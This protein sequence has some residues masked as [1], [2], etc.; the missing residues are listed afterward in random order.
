MWKLWKTT[1]RSDNQPN[2]RIQEAKKLPRNGD[3][4]C[5]EGDAEPQGLTHLPRK[6]SRRMTSSGGVLLM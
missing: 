1:P 4:E 2:N 6:P 3:T 5:I